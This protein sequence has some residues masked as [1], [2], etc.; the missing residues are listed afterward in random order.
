MAD[1]RA[2]L[3][4]PASVTDE[5]D[6]RIGAEIAPELRASSERPQLSSQVDDARKDSRVDDQVL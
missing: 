6:V 3:Q 4:L 5:V 1:V 2:S